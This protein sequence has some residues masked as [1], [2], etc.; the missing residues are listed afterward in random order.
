MSGESDSTIRIDI[1][2]GRRCSTKLH[3]LCALVKVCRDIWAY[4]LCD[5]YTKR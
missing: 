1:R 3:V 4:H 5:L 2:D